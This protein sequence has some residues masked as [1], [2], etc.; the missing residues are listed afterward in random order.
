M[1]YIY[2]NIS[3]QLSYDEYYCDIDRIDVDNKYDYHSKEILKI[4]NI[5]DVNILTNFIVSRVKLEILY[6]DKF[7]RIVCNLILI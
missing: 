1:D 3:K 4:I 5:Q 2:G 6:R 7:N